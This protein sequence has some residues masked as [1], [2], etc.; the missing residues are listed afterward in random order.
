MTDN[1]QLASGVRLLRNYGSQRKYDHEIAGINSRLDPLQAGFLRVKL[2]YLDGWNARRRQ[3]AAVYAE[4]LSGLPWIT[5]PAVPAWAEPAWHLFV[6]RT[7]CR[8]ALQRHLEAA[9]VGTLIHYP[10][11]P[12][13]SGAYAHA[14][15]RPRR[16]SHH[17]GSCG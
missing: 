12:H 15:W 3:L 1:E 13:L 2:K 4:R 14:G 6:I 16:F 11:P 17:R 10:V 8:D 9:G 7:A 5:L